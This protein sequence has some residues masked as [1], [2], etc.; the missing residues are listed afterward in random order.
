MQPEQS[1]ASDEVTKVVD[2]PATIENPYTTLICLYGGMSLLLLILAAWLAW[3]LSKTLPQFV[4]APNP[5]EHV[6]EVA[7]KFH[8][9]AA[10]KRKRQIEKFLKA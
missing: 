1:R 7:R 4:S 10:S 3:R 8:T 6:E 5:Y 2:E 9:S